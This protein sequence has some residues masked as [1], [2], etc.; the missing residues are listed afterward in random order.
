M[1]RPALIGF[2]VVAV[3][4]VLVILVQAA[5]D[6]RDLAFT[7]GV[8]PSQP[9]A[10]LKHGDRACQRPVDVEQG[11]RVVR[12]A[13]GVRTGSAGPVHVTAGRASGSFPAG[14]IAAL[15]QRG[16]R[17]D[18]E[19][20]AGER[21]S[22]CVRNEGRRRVV[23]A[24]GAA[25]ARAGSSEYVNGKDAKVDVALVFDR[26]S[27]RSA[28]AAVPDMFRHASLFRP[29]WVGAWTFWVLLVLVLLAVP[30]LLARALREAA[31]AEG[32]A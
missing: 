11:F 6:D 5:G 15:G 8:S 1:R 10:I 4:G 19:V 24:G 7:L 20:P 18:R 13:L 2:A 32:E 21:V 3:V 31:E 14:P 17:L 26:G 29:G 28:L 27:S 30:A 12:P 25:A 23:L 16:V 9:V 22:V